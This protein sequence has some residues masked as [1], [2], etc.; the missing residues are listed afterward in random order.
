MSTTQLQPA[1]KICIM[2]RPA[3]IGFIDVPHHPNLICMNLLYATD[4]SD[5]ACKCNVLDAGGPHLIILRDI[6]SGT[7]RNKIVKCCPIVGDSAGSLRDPNINQ[8]QSAAT[9]AIAATQ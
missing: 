8:T 3:P 2:G 1:C 7:L 9:I 4:C 6:G 5:T